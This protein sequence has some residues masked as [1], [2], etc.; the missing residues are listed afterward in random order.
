MTG[1]ISIGN[2]SAEDIDLLGRMI[3]AEAGGES[4]L[5]K[6]AVLAV[7][8]NRWRLIKSGQVTPG[9]F[10]TQG[11]KD[12]ITLKDILYGKN[13]FEP[14]SNG[15]LNR[16]TSEQGKLALEKAIRANGNDPQKLYNNLIAQKYSP[17]DAEYIT[18]AAFFATTPNSSFMRAVRLG[19]HVFQQAR[20]AQ[21]KGGIQQIP[22]VEAKVAYN[23]D[24]LAII[25]G[26][27][28]AY[29][30]APESST[31]RPAHSLADLTGH[32]HR[33]LPGWDR[34]GRALNRDFTLVDKNGRTDVPVVSPVNGTVIVAESRGAYGNMIEI[35]PSN[36]SDGPLVLISHF[37][38]PSRLR[39]GDS[40]IQFQ[41]VLGI[42]GMTGGTSSG[43]HVHI[44]AYRHVI[45]RFVRMYRSLS[46]K[47][48]QN[49]PQRNVAMISPIDKKIQKTKITIGGSQDSQIAQI[50]PSMP[51]IPSKVITDRTYDEDRYSGETKILILPIEKSV[52]QLV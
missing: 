22:S 11:T 37:K 4:D 29:G 21:F 3:H 23:G 50:Q 25:S 7:I 34:S 8:L 19:G 26:T 10:L 47:T 12:T 17:E 41:T 27:S 31:G 32:G 49:Q 16:T 51:N 40:V 20:N 6:A 48:P 44:E 2:F 13:Q 42:Q 39:T 38:Y 15:S 9:T 24:Q 45:D 30:L 1:E 52:P 5:G 18:K 14:V 36:P 46:N 43:P 33:P 35:K 28:A